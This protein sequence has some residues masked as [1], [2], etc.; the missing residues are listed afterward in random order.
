MEKRKEFW[1]LMVFS[2]L[3]GLVA[4]LPI[5][6]GG[7][8]GTFYSI[9]P[10][11]MY[12][13]NAL[14]YIKAHQ[15]QYF[16]HPGTPSIL[17]LAYLLW[18][19]RIYA[20]LIA[21]TPFVLWSLGHYDIVFFYLRLW[22]GIVFCLGVFLFL[23]AVNSITNSKLVVLLAWTVMLLFSPVLRLGSG[24]TPE[25]L[26]F[27]MISVWLWLL[28]RFLKK[29]EV[30]LIPVLSLISGLA[31][32]NKFTNLFLVLAS[33]TLAFTLK[34]LSTG[35]RLA[36][37]LIAMI[38][39]ATGFVA[40]TWPIRDKY[41]LLFGW[42]IKLLTSTEIH[43][44]G[45]KAI[46]DWLSY[47]QSVLAVHHQEPWLALVVVLALLTSVFLGQL[48]VL[49]GIFTMG[50]AIFA[51]YPLTYY[52][53]ANYLILVFLLSALFSRLNRF[54]M[55]GLILIL[56]FHVRSNM[57]NHLRSNSLAITKTTALETFVKEHPAEKATLWEWGRAKDPAILLTTSPDWH[58]SMF[59]VEKDALK[60]PVYE[61]YPIPTDKVFDLCWDQLYIQK[62]SVKS[63]LDKYPGQ[64]L[65]YNIIPGSDDMI[66]VKSSHCDDRGR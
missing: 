26:S 34:S 63:F 53:L 4:V 17:S 14:S 61:L 64:P 38:A 28:A 13:G 16:D 29:P 11:V 18:P 45:E 46:F 40:G 27:L 55:M 62:V 59:A 2:L 3:A 31:V 22:Q 48:R 24:I 7:L 32:A 66:L 35:Q 43:A 30:D 23:K 20:K 5:L 65:V 54:L 52:Q 58:G 60:R 1:F 8:K 56:L 10:E 12:V 49:V 37:S 47:K 41:P 6:I 15:I 51:K 44:G 21:Q 50:V 39:A 25:T 57:F 36:N 19:L 42:V 33:V 9:D